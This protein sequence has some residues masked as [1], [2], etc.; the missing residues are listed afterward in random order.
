MEPKSVHIPLSRRV[1]ALAAMLALASC[2]CICTEALSADTLGYSRANYVLPPQVRQT[3]LAFAGC[4][5]PL[6]RNDVHL[7]VLEQL[8]YLLMDSRGRMMEWFD[9]M[10]VYGPMVRQVLEDEKAPPDLIYLAALISDMMPT[11]RNRNGGVGLW[12][13]VA[14]K[15]KKAVTTPWITTESWDDRKDPVLA[16]RIACNIWKTQLND[17]INRDWLLCICAFVDGSDKVEEIADKAKGFSYWD[18]VMPPYSET[19]IPRLAAL[20][21]IDAHRRFYGVDVAPMESMGYDFLGRVKLT[22]DLPL[23]VLAKWCGISSRSI[24][25]LNPG[26]DPLYGI[27]PKADK[28]NPTGFPLRVPKGM[29]QKVMRSLLREAYLP[30]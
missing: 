6:D 13:L 25:E 11:A 2:P 30:T 17:K 29:E 27:L 18:L 23:H 10:D 9:R 8:N 19:L 24:W 1:A 28:K 12:A 3:G 4:T 21:T 16:T 22:K 20:K 5:I 7:R 26:V 14:P 15:G